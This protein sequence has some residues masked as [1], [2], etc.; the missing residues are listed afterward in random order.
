M[1]LFKY[2]E[3]RYGKLAFLLF[4]LA[5]VAVAVASV[6]GGIYAF[7]HLT[8]WARY[9]LLI[10]G[11]VVALCSGG[12]GLFLLA[13]SFSLVGKSK[14]VRDGN[15][16]K[17]ISGTN[18]CDVCGRVIEKHADFCEHCGT[19][20]NNEKKICAKCKTKNNPGAEYCQKCGEKL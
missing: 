4:A 7:N 18:L 10:A 12:F 17:G 9:A 13:I 3:K 16:A 11:I 8:N 19:K 2:R 5:F 15:R 14:S 6:W 20:Q 1:C